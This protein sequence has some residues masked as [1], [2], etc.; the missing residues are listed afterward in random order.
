MLRLLLLVS[1]AA[2]GWAAWKSE[3]MDP[4]GQLALLAGLGVATLAL[5]VDLTLV[6]RR[7]RATRALIAQADSI[8]RGN[9]KMAIVRVQRD[10]DIENLA[11]ALEEMRLTIGREADAREQ[12]EKDY[13]SLFDGTH[14]GAIESTPDGKIVDVNRAAVEMLGYKDKA[15]ILALR[16]SELWAAAERSSDPVTA[17]LGSSDSARTISEVE[18]RR[19]DGEVL[20]VSAIASRSRDPGGRVIAYRTV[21]RDLSER[22]NLEARLRQT[23]K[24]EA[25]GMLAAGVAHEINNPLTYVL[26]HLETIEQDLGGLDSGHPSGSIVESIR[27]RISE[28]LEGA[29]RVKRI[30]RDFKTFSRLEGQER[31]P[32]DINAV[33][34]RALQLASAEIRYRAKVERD[35]KPVPRV[36]ADEGRLAQVFLNLLINAAQA[37]P[38]NSIDRSEIRVRSY[39]EGEHVMVEITDTGKGIEP[40]HL[41]RIFD[42]FFTTKPPNEGSGLGLSICYNIVTSYAGHIEVES[43]PGVGS[44]F[45]VRLPAGRTQPAVAKPPEE[46]PVPPLR[47]RVLVVDDEPFVLST[48]KMILGKTHDVVTCGSGADALQVLER[49][50]RFDVILSDLMMYRS[51]GMD[52]YAALLERNRDLARRMIF[53]TGGAFTEQARRFLASIPNP[54]IDKPFGSVE[55]L[56]V[57]QRVAARAR[58]GTAVATPAPP[59]REG[60][61]RLLPPRGERAAGGSR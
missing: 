21:F 14:D 23:Q 58:T 38:D 42:P 43:A 10:P 37:M 48:A 7:V 60:G 32:V 9:L 15:E 54:R 18:L 31:A 22:K 35:L 13:R 55:L 44:R 1:V 36:I 16:T 61:P 5:L 27:S 8:A 11:N 49:D 2:I 20:A 51:S 19:R 12:K 39:A 50:R 45:T 28:A 46:V 17:L 59:V 47:V 24:L 52:L 4:E 53:M 40:D 41:D 56:N 33:V 6:G 57:V 26:A 30:V 34:E 3:S 25:V 29:G